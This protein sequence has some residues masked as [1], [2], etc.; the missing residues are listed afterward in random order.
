MTVVGEL[1][2]EIIHQNKNVRVT[3]GLV[4]SSLDRQCEIAESGLILVIKSRVRDF[5][6]L[7]LNLYEL[8]LDL[9]FIALDSGHEQV[10]LEHTK[11]NKKP[12]GVDT[13]L[14]AVYTKQDEFDAEKAIYR[15]LSQIKHGNSS[16]KL[17][18]FNISLNKDHFIM[19][20]KNIIE[21]TAELFGLS[22]LLYKSCKA[23][24][25]ILSR[26]NIDIT[27][28]AKKM[29]QKFRLIELDYIQF[30][31]E[32]AY[33]MVFN[34]SKDVKEMKEIIEKLREKKITF[35]NESTLLQN[36]E[37]EHKK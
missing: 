22:T 30:I 29:E 37:A 13:Q 12:W 10:W 20:K 9:Q 32:F 27:Q 4:T 3:L 14:R 35:S 33:D 28:L 21:L 11:E 15:R 17:N 2:K 16:G 31:Q 34:K 19:G 6:I 23:A 8:S 7:I 18:S 5:S 26:H 1:V 25:V 36:K 24:S